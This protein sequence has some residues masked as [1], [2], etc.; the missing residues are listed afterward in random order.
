MSTPNPAIWWVVGGAIAFLA[1][2]IYVPF[3]TELFGFTRLHLIDIV[4]CFMAGI[5][6]VLW[7]EAL[8]VINGREPAIGCYK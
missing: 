2:V 4:I 8:K 6:S 5:A 1:L 3:I 7:F